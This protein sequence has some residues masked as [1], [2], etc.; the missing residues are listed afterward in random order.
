MDFPGTMLP[1][2]AIF[3]NNA[4]VAGRSTLRSPAQSDRL[5]GG[6]TRSVKNPIKTA[7]ILTLL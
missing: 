3:T 1:S 7:T 6:P 5:H 2:I 4:T